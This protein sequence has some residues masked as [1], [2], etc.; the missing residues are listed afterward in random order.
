[1]LEKKAEEKEQEPTTG[2]AQAYTLIDLL[3]NGKKLDLM[4][5]GHMTSRHIENGRNSQRTAKARW[6]VDRTEQYYAPKSSKPDPQLEF[7]YKRSGLTVP[8]VEQA[9]TE[10]P[11]DANFY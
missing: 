4:T 9:E 6:H 3:P 5:S 8:E 10:F 11:E 2:N 7:N 1:M